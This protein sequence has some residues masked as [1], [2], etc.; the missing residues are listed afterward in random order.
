MLKNHAIGSK[1][2]RKDEMH[3]NALLARLETDAALL[4]RK[5]IDVRYVTHQFQSNRS[6]CIAEALRRCNASNRIVFFFSLS[7]AV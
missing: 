5:L 1:K 6:A 2:R 3:R 7:G 4:I